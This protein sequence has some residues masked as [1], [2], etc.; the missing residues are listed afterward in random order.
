MKPNQLGSA[1]LQTGCKT[2]GCKESV[3]LK[4]TPPHNAA[5][6]CLE[7][8][9]WIKWLGRKEKLLLERLSLKSDNPSIQI[10]N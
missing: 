8:N 2:C 9:R 5:V 7:C 10:Y 6:R 4:G 3:I 1:K